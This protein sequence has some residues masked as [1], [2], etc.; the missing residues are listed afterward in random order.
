[1]KQLVVGEISVQNA[2]LWFTTGNV[3]KYR[4]NAL[5]EYFK[6]YSV[7]KIDKYNKQ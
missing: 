2:I 1:M 4:M 6:M 3:E 7:F 5:L